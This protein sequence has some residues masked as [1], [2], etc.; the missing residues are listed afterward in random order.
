MA[1]QQRGE[2]RED[3]FYLH[4]L[5]QCT[6]SSLPPIYLSYLVFSNK[7]L[8]ETNPPESGTGCILMMVRGIMLCMQQR[9][10]NNVTSYQY[11]GSRIHAFLLLWKE[12]LAKVWEER[13]SI[14]ANLLS[15]QSSLLL[16][17]APQ[18]F[19]PQ[20]RDSAACHYPNF[21]IS[22]SSVASS[23]QIYLSLLTGTF[24]RDNRLN[25]AR[26]KKKNSPPAIIFLFYTKS[27]LHHGSHHDAAHCEHLSAALYRSS[28][29]LVKYLFAVLL[30]NGLRCS[31]T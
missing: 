10:T 14:L 30:E 12:F 3:T 17:T 4:F 13:F 18:T 29:L 25:F 7:A 9:V 1:A 11:T 26:K 28:M 27:A 8:Q 31:R 19:S 22:C 6:T 16:S 24:P 15:I 21:F 23:A 20:G 5:I 2:I